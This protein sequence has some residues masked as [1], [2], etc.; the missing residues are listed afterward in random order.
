MTSVKKTVGI[1]L[2]NFR[3]RVRAGKEFNQ[4]ALDMLQTI[5]CLEN[6]T[7]KKEEHVKENLVWRITLTE[8]KNSF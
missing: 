5:S 1:W 8:E 3:A 2:M 6:P 4:R 7:S